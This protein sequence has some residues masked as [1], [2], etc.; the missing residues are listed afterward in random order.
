MQIN[1]TTTRAKQKRRGNRAGCL[2][3][4]FFVAAFVVPLLFAAIFVLPTLGVIR[5]QWFGPLGRVLNAEPMLRS[6][7]GIE[8]R[9][10]SGAD[11]Q[12]YDALAYFPQIQDFA[13]SDATLVKIRLTGVRSD[14]TLDLNAGYTPA[15]RADYTFQR[16]LSTP[17]PNAPPVGAG[18]SATGQWYEPVEVDVYRPGQRR[19]ISR[20]GG[21]GNVTI[22]Y[23]N[24]G[25]Q[26]ETKEAVAQ[27]ATTIPAPTCALAELW[28]QATAQGAPAG[29]VATIEY[30]TNGYRF[31]ITGTSTALSFDTNCQLKPR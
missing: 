23:S 12:H 10:L 4:C 31:T 20:R 13:G 25:V 30:D 3:G 29:A 9:D 17:P 7:F 11:P 18:G 28:R 14:G 15:P 2:A 6:E 21:S 24:R 22:Q 1:V 26:K 8:L 16:M 27:A 5:P 19:S